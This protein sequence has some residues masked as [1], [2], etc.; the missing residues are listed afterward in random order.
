MIPISRP[1]FDEDELSEIKS[2]LES[3]WVSQGPKCKEFEKAIADYTGSKYA[4]A[5]SNC[6]SALH[7]SLLAQGIEPNDEV[8]V[9]DFTFPATGH[10]VMYCNAI[11]VF[12]DINP[13]TYNIDPN[14]I[15]DLIISPDTKAI[16]P[17]HTF[18]QMCDMD[19]IMDIADS[20]DLVVIEDAACALGAKYKGRHAGTIGNTGCFSFHGTKGITT[21]EGGAV[22]TD[23]PEVADKIRSLST[24]GMA[25]AWDRKG[26]SSTIPE[27]TELGYNYKM[28]DISAALVVA[29]MK[30]LDKII[31]KKRALA[32]Y[33]NE[34][35]CG[36][37]SID[38]PHISRGCFHVFQRYVCL[39]D[40]AVDRNSVIR[41]LQQNGIQ[42]TIG[43]YSSFVQ[44]VYKSDE[45][46]PISFDIY[47]RALA[48]PLYYDLKK[49]Q[50]DYIAGELEVAIRDSKK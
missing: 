48:L 34:T 30:K 2:V 1:H 14:G 11:P 45:L 43:T 23:D 28:S 27:F 37:S 12:C 35:L 47:C 17:V 20:H 31:E 40:A 7:L 13:L 4:I 41:K 38:F 39:V 8:I 19:P 29:Q 9:A 6:T 50:I 24:F 5:V 16:I 33:W 15:E 18:G 3:G 32:D 21:G 46:C 44:P 26:D 25:A 49:E 36:V 10:A 22:V 42:T